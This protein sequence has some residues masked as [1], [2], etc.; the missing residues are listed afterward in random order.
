[1]ARLSISIQH[2]KEVTRAIVHE[3]Q[4]H[5]KTPSYQLPIAVPSLGQV[6]QAP[7]CEPCHCG[8]TRIRRGFHR[9]HGRSESE[10]TFVLDKASEQ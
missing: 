6:S 7:G 5:Y 9:R 1:M 2:G 4:P 10:L 3:G 8:K